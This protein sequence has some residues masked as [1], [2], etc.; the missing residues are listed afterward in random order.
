VDTLVQ[1]IS[2]SAAARAVIAA[3]QHTILLH[4][5]AY[6]TVAFYGHYDVQVGRCGWVH[7]RNLWLVYWCS[8]VGI[9]LLLCEHLSKA[10]CSA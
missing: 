4:N 5:P 6:L 9:W 7:M 10:A 2:V 3:P 1:G 8:V